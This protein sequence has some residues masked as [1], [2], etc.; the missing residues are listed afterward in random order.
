LGISV[1]IIDDRVYEPK[2]TFRINL[3][4]ATRAALGSP[5]SQEVTIVDND[6]ALL[7]ISDVTQAE[8]NAGTSVFLFT[9]TL[10]T[11]SV[12]PVTVTYATVNGTA[13]AGSDYTAGS[14]TL[15]FAPGQTSKTVAVAVRGDTTLELNE[16]FF[17]EL[18]GATGAPIAKVRG[19][20]TI[21]NDDGSVVRI[22]DV[23]QAEGQSG[24]TP[25]TFLVTLSRPS[26]TPVVVRYT[27]TDGTATA[28]SDYKALPGPPLVFAVGET[29]KM[30]VVTVKGDTT[31]EP[32][33]TF[34]VNLV[35]ASGA[36]I[37]KSQGIGTILN[38]DGSVLRITDVT[39][40]EGNAGTRPFTFV[41]TV[42]PPSV[43]PVTVG[44]VTANGSAVAGSDYTAVP[45]MLLTFT[46]GQTSKV[47]T[48]NVK[49]DT[50]KEPNETFVVNLGGA[51]G[52]SIFKGQGIGTIL[53]DD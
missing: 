12:S 43:S 19:V 52:A 48:V 38:D 11:P 51:V 25:F 20:G 15:T 17:V 9:V 42:T 22:T 40:P 23:R 39:L 27:I 31:K 7:Q 28:G 8:G 30:I 44:Y 36:T 33:E 4:Q 45:V 1:P 2:E 18:S 35:G 49:G 24:T 46:P 29:R 50:T 14:G 41:V 26:V 47:V 21:L 16:T 32:N 10:S 34:Y 3:T 37:F 13:I 5:A 6:T 53:N